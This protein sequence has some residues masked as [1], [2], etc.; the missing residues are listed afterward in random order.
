MTKRQSYIFVAFFA[1]LFFAACA[2]IGTPDGGP[3][4]ETPP[5]IVRTSPKY[6]STNSRATKVVLEFDENVKLENAAEKVV[7]S[8]PQKEQPEISASGKKITVTLL[9]TLRRNTTYTIDFA[10]AIEDNNEGN[11]MGDYAFTFSTGED[12]DTFQV[13]GHVLDASNLEPI[14]GMLV[15][16]YSVDSLTDTTGTTFPDSIF[17]TKPLERISR[18]D[19]RGHFVIKG[20]APGQYRVFALNDQNQNF[21]FDQKS[22]MVAFTDRVITPSCRPDIRPDTIWHD[23]IHYDSIVMTPYTHFFPDDIVLLAFQEK[24]QDRYLLKN[25]RPVLHQFSLYFTSP[26]DT[27]PLIKG[28]NFDADSAF[29][30]DASENKDTLTYWIRD[31]LIYNIDTL[32]MS[33][34]YYATDTTGMLALTTDTLSLYSR[35][36]KEK[37]EKQKQEAYE[38][39]VKEY[40]RQQ[41]N[42]MKAK[43]KEEKEADEEETVA[44][45][46]DS[47]AETDSEK[48]QPEDTA[49]E[50]TKEKGK[51]KKRQK[52]EEEDI[53]I[54]PMPEELMEVRIVG[55]TV[56]DPNKNI[57]MVVPE[58][59]DTIDMTCFHFSEKI[60]SIY[61]PRQ[62]I[63]RQQPGK[64]LS[65]RLYAEWEPEKTY[66]LVV[67]TGAFVNIYGKHSEGFKKT[68]KVKSLDSYSSLFVTLQNADTSAVVQLM[69]GSDKV[70]STVKSDG[71]KADIYFINPGLYYLRLFYDRNGNGVWDTGDYN[72]HEQAEEVYYYPGGLNLRALWDVSQ[73][74]NVTA[75]PVP[76]QKPEKITKQK[77]D[78]E[79]SIKNRNSERKSKK[80]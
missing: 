79:K 45:T 49:K 65:Y 10:D 70:V 61:E 47:A 46:A 13:S 68:I 63:F 16:L 80:K 30:V 5:K 48:A 12:I 21:L 31:S 72:A 77:P 20:I 44:E 28:L 57:D 14:K 78:K 58:P 33:V 53:V 74:W 62:F 34:T 64:I 56:I 40:K 38:E 39:W 41:K 73:T 11:P 69:D 19:S 50:K 37:M 1:T 71:G 22:E 54:P 27:L 36:S 9:D 4:D 2:N 17:R 35:L 15:G 29:I 8:P 18:T 55:S 24:L 76:K 6:A 23:S 7:I 43:R 32:E 59:I 51:K 3:Y 25:E 75:T 42:A 52:D 67:D 66:E 60:D 26:S